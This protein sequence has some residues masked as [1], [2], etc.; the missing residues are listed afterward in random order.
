[1]KKF[2]PAILI[3]VFVCAIIVIE[4]SPSPEEKE[5]TAQIEE[6]EYLSARPTYYVDNITESEESG[7]EVTLHRNN[8]KADGTLPEKLT[9]TF[10]E[11]YTPSVAYLKKNDSI[12]VN[13]YASSNA[14]RINGRYV[15]TTTYE[16][17][18]FVFVDQIPMLR[19]K[20]RAAYE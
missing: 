7:Y 13:I 15:T 6:V 9:V 10:D 17:D 1:M 14:A 16:A 4:C 11:E 5:E 2:I 19:Q 8:A 12:K 3:G 20:Y 18:L